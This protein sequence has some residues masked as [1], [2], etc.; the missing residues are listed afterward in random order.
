[1][2]NSLESKASKDNTIAI[3]EFA[4]IHIVKFVNP[5]LTGRTA[6]VVADPYWGSLS[7][8]EFEELAFNNFL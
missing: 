8:F 7:P 1:M 5:V 6:V 4:M 2:F 3:D